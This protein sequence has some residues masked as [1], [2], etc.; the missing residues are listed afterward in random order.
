M[1]DTDASFHSGVCSSGIGFAW[2][3]FR[4]S[5]AVHRAQLLDFLLRALSVEIPAPAYMCL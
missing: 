5:L 3:S 4:H 2:N 1:G